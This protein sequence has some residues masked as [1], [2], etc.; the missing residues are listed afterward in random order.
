MTKPVSKNEPAKKDPAKAPERPAAVEHDQ[1]SQAA[2]TAKATVA[3]NTLD[4]SESQLVVGLDTPHRGNEYT[5]LSPVEQGTIQ[6]KL[7]D[8]CHSKERLEKEGYAFADFPLPTGSPRPADLPVPVAAT[9]VTAIVIDCEM[10]GTVDDDNELIH[11]TIIDFFTGRVLLDQLVNPTR[12]I[13]DWRTAITGIDAAMMQTAVQNN[14]ALDGH[15]AACAEL[16]EIADKNSPNTI[17]IGQ[18]LQ[19]DLTVLHTT[20]HATKVIDTAILT[21]EAILGAK[22]SI[23][24]RKRWGLKEL[25]ESLFGIEIRRADGPSS[26]NE[27]QEVVA[28]D[29]L[30]DVLATREVVLSRLL[31]PDEFNRWAQQMGKDFSKKKKQPKKKKKKKHS[32]GY[33][34][35]CDDDDEVLRWEDVVDWDTWPK[36]PP[37]SP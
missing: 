17:L 10:A 1:T 30:E 16:W 5:K 22:K 21:A 19:K 15:E 37:S 14:A 28:H 20:P 11:I 34:C 27:E 26:S 3:A 2:M 29:A 32:H 36:S 35:G 9:A 12:P 24:M 7:L 18:S 33:E 4:E 25:C 23:K 6:R 31:I 13:A 8:L